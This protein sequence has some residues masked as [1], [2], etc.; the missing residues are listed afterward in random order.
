M[1]KMFGKTLVCPLKLIFKASIEE[2]FPGCWKE[3]VV[4]TH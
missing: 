1:I 4:P 2:V 3:T